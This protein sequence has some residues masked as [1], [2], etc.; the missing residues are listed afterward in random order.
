MMQ[1]TKP[2]APS[3]LVRRTDEALL[4]VTFGSTYPGPHRTF[5]HIRKFFA[6]R[7]PDRDIYMAFTSRMCMRRWFEKSGEQYYPA[8]QWLSAI[9]AAGY[10]R[11]SIQ[12]LHVIPGLE[13][14]LIT[15]RYIPQFREAYPEIPVCLG[16][17][18]LWD[19]EDI[20]LVGNVIYEAFAPRLSAGEALVLMGHGNHTDKFPEANGKYDQLNTYL[21]SLDAKI[22]IGTVDYE[23]LLYDHVLEYLNRVCAS[24]TTLNFLPLMS[25]AGDHALNDMV[26]DYDEDEPMHEQSWRTRLLCEGYPSDREEN[27]HLH[28]L[29]DYDAICS[30]WLAHLERA[31]AAL[32]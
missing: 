23:A 24:G 16:E 4:L 8:D 11:V 9:G 30:I 15:D 22:I 29:G 21:Q 20:R 18:L 10:K 25:V 3:E 28:G 7:F 6:D 13:Y 32:G 26:G 17:P 19:D 2:L 5:A 14:S 12:S 31:E 1:T 27:C